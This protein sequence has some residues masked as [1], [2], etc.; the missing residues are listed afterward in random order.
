M[1]GSY[2]KDIWI[3]SAAFFLDQEYIIKNVKEFCQDKQKLS[4]SEYMYKV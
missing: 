1:K 2:I 3:F 4:V